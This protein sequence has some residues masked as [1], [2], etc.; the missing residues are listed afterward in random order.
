[1]KPLIHGLVAIFFKK[2]KQKLGF[3]YSPTLLYRTTRMPQDPVVFLLV[4]IADTSYYAQ[5]P[6]LLCTLAYEDLF[7]EIVHISTLQLLTK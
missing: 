1:M 3:E 6:G 7:L 2:K 5:P 4:T